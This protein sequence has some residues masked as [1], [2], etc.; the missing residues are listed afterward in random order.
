MD[1][2]LKMTAYKNNV[3]SYKLLT[4]EGDDK[5]ARKTLRFGGLQCLRDACF[6]T[7]DTGTDKSAVCWQ[8]PLQHAHEMAAATSHSWVRAGATPVQKQSTSKVL[9]DDLLQLLSSGQD[10]ALSLC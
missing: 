1:A 4:M 8:Y 2:I 5:T 10:A 3:N 6:S 7:A 9:I